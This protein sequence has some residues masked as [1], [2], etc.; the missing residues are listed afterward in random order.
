MKFFDL[1]NK[2]RNLRGASKN[3]IKWDE[4]SLSKFQKAVK[5]FLYP[6][7]K[8][9]LVL[10]EMTIVGTRLSIDIYNATQK[11]A[12][13]VQGQQHIKHNKF[14]HGSRAQGGLRKQF[15][16]DEKKLKFCEINDITMVEIYDVKEC[17][18]EFFEKHGVFL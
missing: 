16:R 6:Y 4:G 10:E 8:G 9:D 5:D 12:I 3:F 11:V 15:E 18:V 7:W 13:E 17:T 2:P 14:F 1:N